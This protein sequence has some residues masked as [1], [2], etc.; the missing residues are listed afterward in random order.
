MNEYVITF[1][2][3]EQITEDSWTVTHPSLKVTD[4]TTIG[5]I[6]KWYRRKVKVG[7]VDVRLTQLEDMNWEGVAK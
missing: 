2:T 6:T 5:E 7:P 4:E 1:E 3:G